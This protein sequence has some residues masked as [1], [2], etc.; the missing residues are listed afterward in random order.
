[1]IGM[2]RACYKKNMTLDFDTDIV[3]CNDCGA[4]FEV[5]YGAW[6]N[7]GTNEAFRPSFLGKR[8]KE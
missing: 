4:K 6:K 3:K 2:C 1:M 7:P 5:I 8:I